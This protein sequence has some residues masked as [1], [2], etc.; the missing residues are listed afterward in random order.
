MQHYS[1]LLALLSMSFGPG[2]SFAAVCAPYRPSREFYLVSCQEGKSVWSF[3]L[4][5]VF[6]LCPQVKQKWVKFALSAIDLTSRKG[7]KWWMSCGSSCCTYR[8]LGYRQKQGVCKITACHNKNKE[9]YGEAHSNVPQRMPAIVNK[10]DELTAELA[11][12]WQTSE[13]R[14]EL[15]FYEEKAGCEHGSPFSVLDFS[16]KSPISCQN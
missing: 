13:L 14:A 1:C 6:D 2:L 15:V 10:S 12:G 11:E 16:E 9:T 4:F 7:M 8:T 3:F 5:S